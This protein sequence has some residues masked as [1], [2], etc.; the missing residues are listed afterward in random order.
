MEARRFTMRR[1]SGTRD[2]RHIDRTIAFFL[3]NLD[4][5]DGPILVLGAL[6][7]C[8]RY[9]DVGE[10]F[11]NIPA[12]KLWVEP[13]RVPPVERVVDVAV[14][15]LQLR[16]EIG[17]LIGLL[18]LGDRLHRNSFHDEMGSDHRDPADAVIL[19]T[20]GIDCR[21]RSAVG[22]P[23]QE[24]A[25][26][27]DFL[28]QL[29]QNLERLD[30]HV[31]ERPRQAG[32]R[33]I[34]IARARIDEHTGP[35]RG[36]KPVRKISPQRNRAKTFVQH[37]DARRVI[38]VGTDHAVFEIGSADAEKAG[39]CE[40]G[41][42]VSFH[43]SVIPDRS[44]SE[45]IRN[46]EI[47]VRRSRFWFR[48]DAR[49]GMTRYHLP[50]RNL[51]RWIFPVAVFGKLSTTSIQ[52][53]Y[54]HTPIFC[55]TCSFSASCNPSVFASAFST[56]KAFGFSKPSGS[57]SGM[58]AASSTAGWVINALSTSNGDTQMPDTLNMSSLRPQK[59]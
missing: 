18:D 47:V 1:M 40:S 51:N 42:G 53:G 43:T 59:V 17:G 29:W 4:L 30:V 24:A 3:G 36:L 21:Y 48:A 15:A 2:H 23:E 46:L 45:L 54:F 11:R 12:A 57:A 28:K 41:H 9:P 8:N 13:C 58:T 39:G 49:P 16:S 35:G 44:R 20:A 14:P 5:A 7:D 26:K 55:L 19:N 56:T 6:Q 31:V 22:M 27:A 34:A 38:G 50:S 10:I 37:D 32:R 33:R 52:R 25:A